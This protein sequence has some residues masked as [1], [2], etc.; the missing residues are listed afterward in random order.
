MTKTNTLLLRYDN[1]TKH[2]IESLMAQDG[3]SNQSEWLRALVAREY[4][5]RNR[6]LVTR[7]TVASTGTLPRPEN[8]D[9]VTLVVIH[10][11]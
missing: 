5:A 3:N 10:E 7:E 2:Q 8:G 1:V 11:A 9:A 4:A 6:T